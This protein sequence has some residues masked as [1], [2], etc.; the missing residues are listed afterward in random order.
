MG[1]RV[2]AVEYSTMTGDAISHVF[3]TFITFDEPRWLHLPRKSGNGNEGADQNYVGRGERIEESQKVSYN[4]SADDTSQK[5]SHVLF[6]SLSGRILWAS[7]EFSPD[8]L[9][10]I[11]DFCK[12]HEEHQQSASS[13]IMTK[14][15]G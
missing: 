9:H 15:F 11:V 12:E 7:E 10:D 6:Y 13:R 5:P 3:D 14:Q 2:Y 1:Q 8:E 4:R